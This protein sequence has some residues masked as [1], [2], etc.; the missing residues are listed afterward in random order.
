MNI[1][2]KLAFGLPTLGLLIA[3]FATHAQSYTV[4]DAIAS[5]TAAIT[6]G[7]G[8]ANSVFF[9]VLPVVVIFVVAII[10]T[11]WGI[12]WV[13]SRFTGGKR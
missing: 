12:R 13:L 6:Q 3:P 10:V 2:Q 11:L 1:K 8:A 7:A 9:G 4:D 5:S